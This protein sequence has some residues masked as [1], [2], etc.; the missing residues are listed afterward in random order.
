MILLY[1]LIIAYTEIKNNGKNN[2]NNNSKS[3]WKFKESSVWDGFTF[4]EYVYAK[5]W[6]NLG[7][8]KY[9]LGKKISDKEFNN[10]PLKYLN[11]LGK[12]NYVIGAV[13]DKQVV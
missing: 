7:Y 10:L 13:E 1:T 11:N 9:E 2:L 4:W 3:A 12:R 6:N 8:N 5:N